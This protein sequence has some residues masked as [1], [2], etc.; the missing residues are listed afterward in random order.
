MKVGRAIRKE[1][2]VTWTKVIV[3]E[4]VRSGW[5]L[6]ILVCILKGKPTILANKLDIGYEK[7]EIKGN[8]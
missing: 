3:T 7:K 5:I 8:S 6:G 4:V 2:I 1:V